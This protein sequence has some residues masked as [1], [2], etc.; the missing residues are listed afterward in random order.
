MPVNSPHNGTG[1]SFKLE[2]ES[3]CHIYIFF[4]LTGAGGFLQQVIFGYTGLRITPDG[5]NQK[6]TPILPKNIKGLTLQNFYIRGKK[7][8][9]TV[10]SNS[11]EFIQEIRSGNL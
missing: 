8:N 6:F 10:N 3:I 7:Y 2:Y 1:L 11:L 5:V 4:N 9:I